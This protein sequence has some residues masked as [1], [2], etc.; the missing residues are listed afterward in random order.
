MLRLFLLILSCLIGS[1]AAAHACPC[2]DN[3]SM[4][5]AMDLQIAELQAK[6]GFLFDG[7]SVSQSGFPNSLVALD[8]EIAEII[9]SATNSSSNKLT[10]KN[11]APGSWINRYLIPTQPRPY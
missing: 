9:K 4:I 7:G 10:V 3:S 5:A 6:R 8:Q 11:A 1:T 2:T